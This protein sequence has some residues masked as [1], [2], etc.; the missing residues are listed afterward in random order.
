MG[1]CLYMGALFLPTTHKVWPQ[2]FLKMRLKKYQ[3]QIWRGRAFPLPCHRRPWLGHRTRGRTCWT[4]WVLSFLLFFDQLD[5]NLKWTRLVKT[6]YECICPLASCILQKRICIFKYVV[7]F[8]S[9]YLCIFWQIKYKRQV[10]FNL[11]TTLKVITHAP[12][13]IS[14]NKYKG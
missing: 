11:L 14:I 3:V 13:S 4:R 9:I 7:F 5:C 10:V 8:K 6:K 2:M 1:L 12:R